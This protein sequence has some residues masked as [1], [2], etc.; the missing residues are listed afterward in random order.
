MPS[1]YEKD[2]RTIEEIFFSKCYILS[3]NSHVVLS[4]LHEMWDIGAISTEGSHE[5]RILRN[6]IPELDVI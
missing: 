5:W 1:C 6:A 3:P 4:G 2:R